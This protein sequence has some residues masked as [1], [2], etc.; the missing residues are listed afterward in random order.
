MILE[1]C[2][3]RASTWSVARIVQNKKLLR[4]LS[5]VCARTLESCANRNH[6]DHSASH[7]SNHRYATT[8]LTLAV[9]VDEFGIGGDEE[10]KLTG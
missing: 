6:S 1:N 3:Q 10:K 8:T 5:S 2:P 4:A 9:G 7:T